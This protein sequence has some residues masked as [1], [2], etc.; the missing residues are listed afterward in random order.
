MPRTLWGSGPKAPSVYCHRAL[1]TLGCFLKDARDAI[2]GS[3]DKIDISVVMR[4]VDHPIEIW[5][6]YPP[7]ITA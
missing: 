6:G 4:N 3:I 2:G 1:L 5:H 7:N